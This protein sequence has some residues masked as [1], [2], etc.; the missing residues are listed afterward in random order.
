VEHKLTSSPRHLRPRRGVTNC[1]MCVCGCVCGCVRTRLVGVVVVA[2]VRLPA[3]LSLIREHAVALDL[4]GAEHGGR[5]HV[6]RTSK[7]IAQRNIQAYRALGCTGGQPLTAGC[8]RALGGAGRL[9]GGGAGGLL[10]G[11]HLRCRRLLAGRLLAGRLLAG[12]LRRRRVLLVGAAR[13]R[14]ALVVL[15]VPVAFGFAV[16]PAQSLVDCGNRMA[17]V[18]TVWHT[19]ISYGIRY[20][21]MAYAQRGIVCQAYDPTLPRMAYDCCQTR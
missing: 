15:V 4:R 5:I 1:T 18:T 21:R 16:L 17:Y 12:L 19:I 13:G 20:D 2:A 10:A 7:N 3:G 14:L 8:P 11:R 6:L 9:L